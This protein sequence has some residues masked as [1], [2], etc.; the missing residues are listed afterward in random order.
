MKAKSNKSKTNKSSSKS[1]AAKRVQ[2]VAVDKLTAATKIIFKSPR[3][4]GV[5]NEAK[6]KL[7]ALVPKS[8]GI[9][10]KQLAAKATKALGV[11]EERISRWM[12][13]LARYGR[14]SLQ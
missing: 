1:T 14:V 12:T 6:T 3:P 7:L 5:G 4:K 9:T 2:K 8:G 11:P 10:F 13:S